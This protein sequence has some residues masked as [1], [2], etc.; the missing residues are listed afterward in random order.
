MIKVNSEDVQVFEYSDENA[1]NQE[2][3]SISPD[4]ST[5]G[6]TMVSWVGPPHFFRARKI[7]V[8]YIGEDQAV[9]NLLEGSLGKQFA[10]R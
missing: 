6:T 1:A 8:L 4:G 9:I 5:V 3:A 7:I 10:G 2:A